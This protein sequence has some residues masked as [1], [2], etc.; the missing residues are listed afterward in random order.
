MP[1]IVQPD[2]RRSFLAE[3]A[4]AS[5]QLL[6]EAARESLR[7][8][9]LAL[10]SA[11]DQCVITGQPKVDAGTGGTPAPQSGNGLWVEIDEALLAGFRRALIERIA[12][13]FRAHKPDGA[14]YA[15]PASVGVEVAPAQSESLAT[16]HSAVCEYP[17]RH[18]VT[19][20]A[21]GGPGEAR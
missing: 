5:G 15:D 11:E 16:P 3:L 9:M 17:P 12:L 13:T 21:L 19:A 2:H 7:M 8:L 1:Q 14:P 18:D 6:S 4:P 10:E 20:A